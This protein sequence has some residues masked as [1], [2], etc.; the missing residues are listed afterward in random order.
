MLLNK[1]LIK[2]DPAF[3]GIMKLWGLRSLYLAPSYKG[4]ILSERMV[5]LQFLYKKMISS[6]FLSTLD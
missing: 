1:D 3:Y 4:T 2:V 5:Y 6:N